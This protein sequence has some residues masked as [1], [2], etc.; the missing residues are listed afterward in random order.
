M[1]NVDLSINVLNTNVFLK[2]QQ[3][4][5]AQD[6]SCFK[7]YCEAKLVFKNSVFKT[8]EYNPSTNTIIISSY[9]S[10]YLWSIAY[11]FF[12]VT[13]EMARE[14]LNGLINTGGFEINTDERHNAYDLLLYARNLPHSQDVLWPEKAPEPKNP[15]KYSLLENEYIP[16]V[17][18][19]Y[20]NGMSFIILHECA[21]HW[22]GHR[23]PKNPSDQIILEQQ[24]DEFALKQMF[25]KGAND[26]TI[27]LGVA[28][29]AIG[30]LYCDSVFSLKKESHEDTD[31]RLD[32]IVNEIRLKSPEHS[33][34]VLHMLSN[35]I[36]L[37]LEKDAPMHVA[38]S[39][40]IGVMDSFFKRLIDKLSELKTYNK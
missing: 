37:F 7:K 12:F 33:E 35:G 3:F 14:Q 36:N 8:P 24:A 2:L 25:S 38:E 13:E 1:E 19:F 20:I 11:F 18:D 39:C 40:T 21:H 31:V 6:N 15:E 30:M 10:G 5:I 29:A 32:K 26:W 22:Y 23:K 17:N 9:F 28:I 27:T 16:K 4:L 34:Y